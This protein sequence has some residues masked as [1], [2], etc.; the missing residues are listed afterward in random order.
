MPVLRQGIILNLLFLLLIDI[1]RIRG[2]RLLV[3]S[4]LLSKGGSRD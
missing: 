3:R 2:V 1:I 4:K